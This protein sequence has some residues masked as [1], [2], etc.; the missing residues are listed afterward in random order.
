MNNTLSWVAIGISSLA[1]VVSLVASNQPKL[2]PAEITR[3]LQTQIKSLQQQAE[4]S[5][6]S[7]RLEDLKQKA[8][9]GGTDFVTQAQVEVAQIREDLRKNFETAGENTK[10]SWQ[11]L[12]NQLAILQENLKTG[13]VNVIDAIDKI[14]QNL[15]NNLQHD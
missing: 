9:A 8:A 7:Q 3:D 4:I 2:N 6:A 5:N 10:K 11:D 12:D 15:K 13:G 14:L 1:L